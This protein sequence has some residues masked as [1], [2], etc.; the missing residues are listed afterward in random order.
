MGG[1]MGIGVMEWL[2]KGVTNLWMAN[3]FG[4]RSRSTLDHFWTAPFLDR[5]S[6]NLTFLSSSGRLYT[7]AVPYCHGPSGY[8]EAMSTDSASSGAAAS[9]LSARGPVRHN[10]RNLRPH[11]HAVHRFWGM[12]ESLWVFGAEL[13]QSDI[14][15]T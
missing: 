1:K 11:C 8:R 3:P 10:I 7:E 15:L 2:R 13:D 5:I 4:R 12:Y 6:A 9:T 14:W